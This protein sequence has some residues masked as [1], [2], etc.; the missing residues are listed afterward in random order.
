MEET[1]PSPTRATWC[2]RWRRHK[3]G[4]VG[5]NGHSGAG[6]NDDPSLATASIL[7]FVPLRWAVNNLGV[8]GS[9]DR[10]DYVFACTLGRQVDGTALS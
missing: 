4:Q 9:V 6:F 8:D 3:A 2:P 1:I 7:R 5:A 10:L